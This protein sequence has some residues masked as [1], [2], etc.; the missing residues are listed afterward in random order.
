MVDQ[1]NMRLESLQAKFPNNYR[2]VNLRGT[3]L[4]GEWADEL[5]PRESGVVKTA[6]KFA[7][8]LN[9]LPASAQ[10]AMPRFERPIGM[11]LAFR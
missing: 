4:E 8:A 6:A 10:V 5:H 7:V 9:A 3:V 11:A 2:Y 1:W